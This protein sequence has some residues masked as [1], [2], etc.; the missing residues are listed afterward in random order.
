MCQVVLQLDP[1]DTGAEAFVVT[2][3][4]RPHHTSDESFKGSVAACRRSTESTRQVELLPHWRHDVRD[5]PST[6]LHVRAV[7][8]SAAPELLVLEG[9]LPALACRGLF[10]MASCPWAMSA[11][12]WSP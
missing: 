6:L 9:R 2:A 4:P 11:R 5:A 3:P 7:F 1:L 12:R 8:F 10:E